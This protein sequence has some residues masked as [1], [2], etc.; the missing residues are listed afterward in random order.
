MIEFSD[1]EIR[2]NRHLFHNQPLIGVI[3]TLSYLR[4]NIRIAQQKAGLML[5]S[6]IDK[7]LRPLHEYQD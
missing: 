6:T 4:N 1:R 3:G 7:P 2:W 5:L